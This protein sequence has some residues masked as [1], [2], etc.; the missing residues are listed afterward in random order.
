MRRCHRLAS[1]AAA[2][3]LAACAAH[4]ERQPSL[5][6]VVLDTVRVDAVSAYGRVAGTTP[7]LDRLAAEGVLYERAYAQAP[8]TLPSHAT[9]FTGL[10]PEDHGVSSRRLVASEE[11]VMLA[12]R[13]RDAGYETMGSS[14]NPWIHPLTRM[15]QGFD[16][17]V[18]PTPGGGRSDG[19]PC[20]RCA[21]GWSIARRSGP[22]SSS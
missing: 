5:V 18:A 8:W 14:E 21:P 11:L 6:L 7:A 13:L 10:P 1:W 19:R 3:A 17:F 20:R 4:E 22:S 2:F 16:H 12:E 9:L 15:T